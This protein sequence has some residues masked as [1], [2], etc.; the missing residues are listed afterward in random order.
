MPSELDK[1]ISLSFDED[2]EVRKR[3]AKELGKYPDIGALLALLEL[4]RDKD[5]E[6]ARIARETADQLKETLKNQEEMQE[7]SSIIA[8]L[9]QKN[10][11]E[12]EEG[13]EEEIKVLE[14]VLEKSQLAEEK[15][16]IIKEK[17]QTKEERHSFIDM[18][19]NI[20]PTTPSTPAE[21]A[22]QE[23]EELSDEDTNLILKELEQLE[24]EYKIYEKAMV[25]N[26]IKPTFLRLLYDAL[27][28]H[29]GNEKA[30]EKEFK[31]I[32]K[33]VD[34][35]LDLLYEAFKRYHLKKGVVDISK[36]K[37][38]MRGIDTGDLII[39]RIEVKEIKHG[40][41]KLKLA[42]IY[43]EDFEGKEGVI[44]VDSER[45]KFLTPGM[46]IKVKNGIGKTFKSTGETVIY[47]GKISSIVME[48]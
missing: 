40:R 46:K 15:K 45:A 27:Y 16:Q 18:L 9:Q 20:L 33:F 11:Q 30:V 26:D 24:K 38:K 47:I 22:T 14:D 34:K 32:K 4:S 35:E 42:M 37:D 17:V 29:R 39:K 8:Q 48:A 43:V 31:L 23:K 21:A 2:P 12:G 25:F 36:I 6:V 41:K 7:I 1:L 13:G 28:I 19:K 44:Y 5:P 3:A 10:V